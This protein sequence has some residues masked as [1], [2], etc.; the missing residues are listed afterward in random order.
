M[1]VPCSLVITCWE[2]AGLLA[3]LCVMFSCVFVTFSY[4]VLG[5]VWHLVQLIPD[6]YFLPY[7][8][9]CELVTLKQACTATTIVEILEDANLVNVLSRE[10]IMMTKMLECAVCSVLLMF[11]NNISF[12]HVKNQNRISSETIVYKKESKDQETIQ[13]STKPDPGHRIGK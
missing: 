7:F 8:V 10:R 2:R 6:L 5:Q 12:F 1:S 4:D 3:L 9:V 11:V 13:S